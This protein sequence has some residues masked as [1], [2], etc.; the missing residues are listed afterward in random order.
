MIDA[1]VLIRE[2]KGINKRLER[3]E[4]IKDGIIEL[5]AIMF[6]AKGMSIKDDSMFGSSGFDNAYKT[7]Y[8]HEMDK[9]DELEKEQRKLL[10]EIA[11]LYTIRD[12]CTDFVKEA[13]SKVYIYGTLSIQEY[14][15]AHGVARRQTT[16][17]RI[18]RE[19]NNICKK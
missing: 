2:F 19:L 15:I 13:I 10:K 4:I 3:L 12:R 6:S 16:Y 11:D 18:V 14:S 7:P 1:Q 8:L 5:K 17:E 9:L